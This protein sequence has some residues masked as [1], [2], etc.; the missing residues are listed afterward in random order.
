[1]VSV[2]DAMP[3][4]AAHI[5]RSIS[6]I[7]GVQDAVVAGSVFAGKA[8]EIEV[9][10]NDVDGS[11]GGIRRRR[12]GRGARGARLGAAGGLRRGVPGG[13]GGPARAEAPGDEESAQPGKPAA[14]SATAAGWFGQFR[15]S[16]PPVPRRRKRRARAPPDA[17]ARRQRR[18]RGQRA[19]RG[20]RQRL[21]PSGSARVPSSS[22]HSHAS[23]RLPGPASPG[24]GAKSNSSRR[25]G[26]GWPPGYEPLQRET[27]AGA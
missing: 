6:K 9:C 22:A 15:N 27:G 16:P 14:A 1:M 20:E 7:G 25:L 24:T 3:S 26:K 21:I 12:H 10:I 5:A 19:R 18:L 17:R 13:G 4:A 8:D 11:R 23:G 2:Q